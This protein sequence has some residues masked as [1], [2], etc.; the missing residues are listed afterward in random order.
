MVVRLYLSVY[1]RC[2][3][4]PSAQG[5]RSIPMRFDRFDPEESGV[6]GG[7]EEMVPTDDER[8]VNLQEIQSIHIVIPKLQIF[9]QRTNEKVVSCRRV[10]G[11]FQKPSRL[12]NLCRCNQETSSG[13]G[14][15]VIFPYLLCRAA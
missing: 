1:S 12:R 5:Q 3:D 8:D 9:S 15:G 6:Y 4:D 7:D 13:I 11:C 10:L 2:V 14:L